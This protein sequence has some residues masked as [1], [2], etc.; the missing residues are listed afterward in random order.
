MFI[1]PELNRMWKRRFFCF[2]LYDG[3]MLNF[4][5]Q[6]M[7]LNRLGRTGWK[8]KGIKELL[9][10]NKILITRLVNV[11]FLCFALLHFRLF[12]RF[13]FFSLTQDDC[14]VYINRNHLIYYLLNAVFIYDGWIRKVMA[15]QKWFL[16]NYIW[17]F[18]IP[19]CFYEGVCFFRYFDTVFLLNENLLRCNGRPES[20]R[21]NFKMQSTEI[22][23][24]IGLHH[25]NALIILF[26][27]NFLIC[28]NA[29]CF[30]ILWPCAH[31][32]LSTLKESLLLRPTGHLRYFNPFQ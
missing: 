19:S 24:V 30:P 6:Q 8:E 27:F 12:I 18:N 13:D 14:L 15:K 32:D 2:V 17:L 21:K 25:L 4:N 26:L 29:K 31:I 5:G 1:Y 22:V 3:K 23:E 7:K 28:K 10:E 11:H 16:A 20:Y 9:F